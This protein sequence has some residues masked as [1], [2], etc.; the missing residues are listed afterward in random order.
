MGNQFTTT[1]AT[2]PTASGY[3]DVAEADAMAATMP[4][5][6]S[7]T[8]ASSGKQA[9]LDEASWRVDTLR[10]QGR[11][12]DPAQ[13]LEFPRVAYDSG[14]IGFPVPQLRDPRTLTVPDVV[15]DWDADAKAAVV[16]AAV[17]RAVLYEA[18][19][20]ISGKRDAAL[21]AQQ[22][23]LASQSIGSASETYR[24]PTAGAG[25]ALSLCR[26]AMQLLQQYQLRSGRIT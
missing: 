20:I 12:Y 23:G 17:K 15:W 6:A 10:F 11:K 18:D 16:P 1:S 4:G 14:A 8:G 13:R 25:G 26:Q 2:S 5:L 3:L 19:S 21:D 22:A 9:A 24:A 7:Y